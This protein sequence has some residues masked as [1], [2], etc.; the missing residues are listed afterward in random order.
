MAEL[1]VDPVVQVV[2]RRAALAWLRRSLETDCSNMCWM[3]VVVAELQK[4]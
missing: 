4:V 3:H 1:A 2:Y